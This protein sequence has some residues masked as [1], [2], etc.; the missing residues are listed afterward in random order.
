[1]KNIL[2]KF[3][4]HSS[5]IYF[6]LIC[7]LCGY[8]KNILI[9][10]F[11]VCIH[12]LGHVLVISFFHYPI[13]KII[14]YPFGGMT[15]FQK[16]LNSS[17]KKDL[18]IACAGVIFQFLVLKVVVRCSFL[19]PQTVDLLNGYNKTILLFNLLPIIPLDGSKIIE[20]LFNK[21]FSYKISYYAI[22]VISI[23][24]SFYF[25][26][27]QSSFSLNNYL[28]LSIFIYYI[29]K[30]LKEF[31]YMYNKFLLE[32]ILYDLPYDKIIYNTKTIE[33]LKREKY[34][35]FYENN[36]YRNEKEKIAE[37]FDKNT[38]F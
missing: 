23:L 30:Y 28:I 10:F 7:F 12:E 14:I 3:E 21:L 29:I 35:Y 22:V 33:Q 36:K 11:I 8:I 27:I 37:K 38:Y 6:L 18:V 19:M 25:F 24:F 5:T 34:H 16:L 31:R 1:M 32:R 15:I 2:N 20:C 17:I 9:L 26:Q 13:D 4:I